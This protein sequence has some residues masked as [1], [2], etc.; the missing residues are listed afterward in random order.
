MATKTFEELKQ[1]AIQ[2]RDEKTNKQN[3]ATRVGTAMLE[4]INK[5]EQ[6]Y[7]DK[8]QTDEELKEQDDKL[9]ELDN[10]IDYVEKYENYIS[11]FEY[12]VTTIRVKDVI[13]NN[14]ILLTENG[15]TEQSDEYYT[16]DYIE[17]TNEYIISGVWI[18]PLMEKYCGIA[19]YDEEKRFIIALGGDAYSNTL[20]DTSLQK[21]K[22]VKYLRFT[23]QG[24][25][26]TS[27]FRYSRRILVKDKLKELEYPVFKTERL[28]GSII[29]PNN[30][31]LKNNGLTE[32][33]S[34]LY[35]SD[36][37]EVNKDT[38]VR[39]KWVWP[40][41]YSFAGIVL[42]NKIKQVIYATGG[43]GSNGIVNAVRLCD[44]TDNADISYM[45]VC[46]NVENNEDDFYFEYTINDKIIN[47]IENI[48]YTNEINV[49]VGKDYESIEEALES[50][51]NPSEKNRYKI[52]VNE[53]EYNLDTSRYNCYPTRDYTTIE[54]VNRDKV[55]VKA[56]FSTTDYDSQK[57]TFDVIP[58]SNT[59]HYTAFKNMTIICQGGKCPIHIDNPNNAGATIDIDNCILIDLNTN[60]MNKIPL[61]EGVY[62][63]GGINCG[64]CNKTI[65]NINRCIANGGIYAHSYT[66]D[67]IGQAVFYIKNSF[68][69]D[70]TI[71]AIG[72]T[73]VP[74]K[75]NK[76]ILEDCTAR[77]VYIENT[78][79][80]EW[81]I[82]SKGR[83][84]IGY[85]GRIL[86]TTTSEVEVFCKDIQKFVYN[87]SDEIIS[88]GE[89]LEY[90]NI[91]GQSPM[92]I[93]VAKANNGIFAGMAMQTIKPKSF[94]IMQH[95]GIID[96]GEISDV[97]I[98]D[99]LKLQDGKIIK[100]ENDEYIGRYEGIDMYKKYMMYIDSVVE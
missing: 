31:V 47:K 43:V 46:L 20:E 36:Y 30:L 42:Y 80:K 48:A 73:M 41:V 54:G 18:F 34:G 53:G 21:Y 94:G 64:I 39:G 85:Y 51:V 87:N 27:E 96:I 35:T 16:S 62:G 24:D 29:T 13:V 82:I 9:T 14:E 4:H 79:N 98:G 63:A 23:F 78:S 99:K 77:N 17:V 59:F 86:P 92:G 12:P 55:I 19:L 89:L 68:F 10:R 72:A 58:A 52:I 15:E 81:D 60:N 49:G 75:R 26:E 8:N 65:I 69:K 61:Y 1:L 37:I 97:T 88:Y 57:N 56:I 33:S 90:Q 6:D 74:T 32:E 71:G 70:T 67:K 28:D 11:V 66:G 91:F 50:I 22:D 84:N 40:L 44:L 45:R 100:S 5:L 95:K 38:I 2:I 25:K 76:Y 7:Y 83:N 93:F 3:T